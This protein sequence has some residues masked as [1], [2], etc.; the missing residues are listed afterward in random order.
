MVYGTDVVL[1]INLALL[2]MKL[3]Q[4]Q[5]EQPNHV[6]RRINQLIEVQQHRVEVDE[7]LQK[8]QDDMK[9]LF[10]CRAKDRDFL[11]GDLLLKWDARREEEAKH[12]KFDHLWYG[13]FRVSALEGKNYFLMEN[14]D[15]EILNTPVNRH[16]LKHYMT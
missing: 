5:N 12:G 7:N 9:V 6:T 16:Y 15:G 10:D 14:I 11:P 2:V 4:D 13:P 1:P 8:Y 3:W